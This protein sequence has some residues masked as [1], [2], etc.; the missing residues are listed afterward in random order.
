MTL[1]FLLILPVEHI[2]MTIHALIIGQ[3]SGMQQAVSETLTSV[4]SATYFQ[5]LSTALSQDHNPVTPHLILICQQWPEEYTSEEV[6]QLLTK[7]PLSRFV[8]CYSDWCRSDGRT[9][10]IWPGAI[11]VAPEQSAK[12]IRLECEVIKGKRA[13][14]PITAG[15]EE[16]FTFEE[17]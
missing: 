7:F 1:T 12:R 6:N 15:Y 3:A 14:L 5:S 16:V 11:R 9:R 4:D 8:V 2:S 13:A 10:N 17:A